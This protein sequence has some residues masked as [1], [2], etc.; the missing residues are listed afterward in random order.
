MLC[1]QTG[2]G[3]VEA[4]RDNPAVVED[5]EIAGAKNFGQIAEEV[6]SVFSGTAVEAEHAAGAANR[7]RRLGDEF[8]GKI[9]MKVGYAHWFLF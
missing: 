6:V 3:G 9:E 5:E 2:A 4:R 8:F 1:M 7:R